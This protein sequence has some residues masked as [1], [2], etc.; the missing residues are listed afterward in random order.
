MQQ[1]LSCASYLEAAE[2]EIRSAWMS[3]SL[4]LSTSRLIHRYIS[5]TGRFRLGSGDASFRDCVL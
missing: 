4:D 5:A 1:H 2:S 3:I